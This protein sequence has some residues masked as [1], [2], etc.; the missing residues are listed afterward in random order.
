VQ[1]SIKKGSTII[2][3]LLVRSVLR[4]VLNETLKTE[5]NQSGALGGD[6]MTSFN[7]AVASKSFQSDETRGQSGGS[8]LCHLCHD[9]NCHG[10][11]DAGGGRAKQ[12]DK[13]SSKRNAPRIAPVTPSFES[14][15]TRFVIDTSLSTR[16]SAEDGGRRGVTEKN[17]EG[18]REDNSRREY[19]AT[20]EKQDGHRALFSVLDAIEMKYSSRVVS[21]QGSAR[22]FDHIGGLG[23]H[24][25][26]C[27]CVCVC[28]PV[29]LYVCEHM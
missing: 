10:D 22:Y 23:V 19:D 15:T 17:S 25:C 11:D 4:S 26:R 8:Y 16:I 21:S 5:S 7:L 28:V 13:A 14:T 20:S 6:S 9:R 24:M 1:L 2:T 12:G 3:V 18:S 29:C 27:V